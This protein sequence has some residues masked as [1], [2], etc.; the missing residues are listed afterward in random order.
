M[1][2][3][4]INPAF[5][6]QMQ[7]RVIG[8]RSAIELQQQL[9]AN[10][11]PS[12]QPTLAISFCN[13]SLLNA[14]I[15]SLYKEAGL[16][17]FGS[18]SREEIAVGRIQRNSVCSMLLD[19][20]PDFF[21]LSAFLLG[22]KT[23]LQLGQ[24]VGRWARDC[25][26]KP[27]LL[28]LVGGAGFTVH[29]E[30]LIQGILNQAPDTPLFGGLASMRQFSG[31]AFVYDNQAVIRDGIVALALDRNHLD[32]SGIAISGWMEI[33]TPKRITRSQGNVV[34][35]IDHQPATRIYEKYFQTNPE[36]EANEIFALM[37][38]PLQVTRQDQSKVMRVPIDL[39]QEQGSVSFA[40]AMPESSLVRF[41]SPN[42]V[43]TI[44]HTVQE[45]DRFRNRA[46]QNS[47]AILLFDC[48]IRSN[49]FGTY[50]QREVDLIHRIWQRPMIGF[51]SWGEVG[52][53]HGESCDLH[54]TTLSLVVLRDVNSV[55]GELE[56]GQRLDSDTVDQ[57]LEPSPEQ[58]DLAALREEVTDLRKQKVMLS[59]FLA[60]HS[61]DLDRANRELAVEQA[62]S[63]NLLLNVLP[64]PVAA[65]L[66]A[67]EKT[68]ADHYD[69][70]S[71]LFA[72]LV[73]FTSLSAQKNARDVVKLLNRLFINFDSLAIKYG[74]EKIKTIGDAYM[75]VS[76][77]PKKRADHAWRCVRLAQ[78]ML[79]IMRQ[80]NDRYGT[81]LDLRIGI[82]S[83]SVVAGVIGSNKFSYDLW[84]DTVNVA[85]RMESH[86]LPGRIHLADSTKI[87][88]EG[89]FRFESRGEIAIKGKGSMQ[90]WLV[91]QDL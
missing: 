66:K 61:E 12:F 43:E 84:G 77:L 72:D 26:E 54:N 53:R 15:P 19:P 34:F 85:S 51:S 21:C 86:G 88:C 24:S 75:A 8:S 10:T 79:R 23:S 40:G 74:T 27:A 25:F 71:I 47:D 49:S 45:I 41:C 68:I 65:R 52:A 87:L 38:Y 2:G 58:K 32:L 7:V 50:M 90:T 17:V 64:S 14:G 16:Q 28:M 42:I 82:N 5:S 18:S 48:A 9:E 63:E 46:N 91:V 59:N 57:L 62:R 69:S 3:Q 33:G 76:G 1:I 29:T 30:Q 20:D 31:E 11:G 22:E 6:G 4:T 83:G 56:P 13:D 80:Y 60:L 36:Q 44:R 78:A 70:V 89:Q 37:E 35:E 81:Q 39:N 55:P 73:G 67:G